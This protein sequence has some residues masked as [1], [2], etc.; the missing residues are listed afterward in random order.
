MFP[1]VLAT[2]GGSGTRLYPLTLDQPKPL[3]ELC[4]T[5]IIANLFRVLASQGCRRFILGSKGASNTLNLS[6][7]FKAGEGFFK[8]LGITDH[9][10]FSYQPLY[11]DT[12][13]ADSMR[14]CMNYYNIND[15]I[16]VVSGDNLIDIDLARFVQF[17]REQKPLL[18]VA[19][20]E[21]GPEENIS[22]YGVARVD[23]DMR[24]LGFVEKP[25]TGCEPSRMINTAFYLFSP[26]IREVLAEMGNRGRDIG[27][28]LIPYLTEKGY[29]VYGYPIK[30]YWMDIGTPERLHQ[31]SM[32]CLSGA[33]RHFDRKYHYKPN[34]W[35]HPS[36][37]ARIEPLLAAGEIE[38][39][40]NVSI[41]RNCHIEKGVVIENSHIG[42]TSLI[43]RN[44]EIR[45]SMIMSFAHIQHMVNIRRAIVGRHTT[46]EE[47]SVL[48]GDSDNGQR[49]IAVIGENATI[50]PESV[51]PAGV[52]VAPL[53][54]S[55]SILATGRFAEL[56]IDE[57][58]I[59]FAEKSSMKR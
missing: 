52:R 33:V 23:D 20:K 13:S 6:N 26:R 55:H 28:D 18:T 56:G 37:L 3:V 2:V 47:H 15:D 48:G 45:E 29:P 49:L 19:L 38:L 42:H 31:A 32:D 8:R 44:V 5:A 59:Y 51:V 41:G 4:D 7:Y 58:N 57:R 43:E 16:L 53:K 36:T 40:G 50:P 35:I 17:H 21:L 22:Q 39:I 34:Q 27:G 9:Q 25:K 14:Y 46:I 12:G 10:D 54:H 30:G 24:I 11:D 1:H